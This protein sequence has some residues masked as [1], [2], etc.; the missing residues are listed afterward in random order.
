MD[1][2]E[3]YS[4][5]IPRHYIAPELYIGT[6]ETIR[7]TEISCMCM[8]ALSCIIYEMYTKT[9]LFNATNSKL[10]N[11]HSK[12]FLK[13]FNLINFSFRSSEAYI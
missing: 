5:L 11:Y 8:W 1:V 9:R 2:E 12:P 3:P 4:F 7:A 10:N 13:N 6:L